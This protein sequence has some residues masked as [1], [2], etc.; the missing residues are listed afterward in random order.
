MRQHEAGN[1]LRARFVQSL[2]L[3]RRERLQITRHLPI[4]GCDEDQPF[5]LRALLEFEQALHG[6]AIIRVATQAVAGL[7]GVSNQSAARK[8]RSDRA[9]G[10]N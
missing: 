10:G 7:G 5:A 1:R 6:S 9:S 2:L 3:R 4:T 8:M